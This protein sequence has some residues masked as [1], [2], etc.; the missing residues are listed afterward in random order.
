MSERGKRTDSLTVEVFYQVGDPAFII[1]VNGRITTDG[2]AEVERWMEAEAERLFTA[3]SGIYLCCPTFE[4]CGLP[5]EP[6]GGWYVEAAELLGPLVPDTPEAVAAME[7]ED[8]AAGVSRCADCGWGM[9]LDTA[10]CAYCEKLVCDSCYAGRHERAECSGD[11][12][13]SDYRSG[14]GGENVADAQWDRI[15]A[16]GREW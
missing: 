5:D 1:A 9:H 10:R 2:L 14:D 11:S 6:P 12:R 7:A 4:P 8:A 16:E 3:G 13:P 15:N